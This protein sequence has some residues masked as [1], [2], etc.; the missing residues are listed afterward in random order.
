MY[1]SDYI[2]ELNNLGKMQSIVDTKDKVLAGDIERPLKK[3]A[4]TMTATPNNYTQGLRVGSRA[5]CGSRTDFLY[6]R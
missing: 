5:A 6:R 1:I 3:A 4:F 2:E